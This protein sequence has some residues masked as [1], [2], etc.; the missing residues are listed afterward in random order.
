MVGVETEAA[1]VMG[2]VT[3][4][5]VRVEVVGLVGEGSVADLEAVTAVVVEEEAME[6]ETAVGDLVAEAEA[7]GGTCKHRYGRPRPRNTY[8]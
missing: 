8:C 6:E 4:A 7:A 5:E 1:E 3:E 2:V